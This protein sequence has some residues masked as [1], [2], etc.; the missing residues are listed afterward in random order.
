MS[1]GLSTIVIKKLRGKK[2]FVDEYQRGYKWASQQVLDLLEDIS[3][4]DEKKEAFYCLQPLAVK[5]RPSKK[6]NQIEEYEVIDGQQR[7][8]TI[9]IILQVI[10]EQLY[11]LSYQTRQGSEEFLNKIQEKIGNEITISFTKNIQELTNSINTKWKEYTFKNN[12]YD[13]ID[14]YHFFSAFL[15][16]KAWFNNDEN[17]KST[18]QNKLLEYTR[19]I[20]FEDKRS[21]NPKLIFRNL[22]SGKIPLT[23]AELIKALFI[24]NF[25]EDNLEARELKQNTFA[26]EWDNIEQE[27]YDDKFWFFI[28]NNT[29]KDRYQTRIDFIFELIVGRVPKENRDLLYTYREYAN[30]N[31]ELDWSKVKELYL[32]LKEWYTDNKL[33]HLI[34]YIIDRDFKKIADLIELSHGIN[35]SK[36]ELELIS[37][38]KNRLKLAG[39]VDDKIKSIQTINYED[40]RKFIESVLLLFNIVEYQNGMMN[41]RFPFEK[42]K[43]TKWS[44]EH[45]HA[46]NSK[47]FSTIQELK[48]WLLEMELVIADDDLQSSEKEEVIQKLRMIKSKIINL[49]DDEKIS[50]E[51]KQTLEAT[52]TITSD[53]LK[54]HNIDNLA[55]LDG[56]TNSGL[57]NKVFKE[58]RNYLLEIDKSSVTNKAFIP[59]ATKN[60]FQKYYTS[61]VKQHEFWGYQDRTDYLEA[62]KLRLDIYFTEI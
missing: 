42:F 43:N 31:I 6:P 22:N 29:N 20:W 48:A 34:G 25:Q 56:A 17:K 5:L 46:Q 13:N 44:I 3:S 52:I 7:L 35:K 2:F 10:D 15:L 37:I 27:L 16:I 49:G 11:S 62:L 40:D 39:V 28:N 58:K 38:I 61:D 14:I 54:V 36:F 59:L 21:E 26:S 57:G 60:V 24:N 51:I 41:F 32:K 30:Q 55:L 33:Y 1:N 53:L 50:T 18:F 19:F 47:E 23:N 12:Q 4:F 8:T 9:F 45:I